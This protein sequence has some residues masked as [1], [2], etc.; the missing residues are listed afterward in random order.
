[1]GISIRA[2]ARHRGVAHNA[3][4]KAIKAGRIQLNKDKTIDVTQADLDWEQNTNPA[5]AGSAT[6]DSVK[7]PSLSTSPHRTSNP[8]P[9]TSGSAP[10]SNSYA[11]VRIAHEVAKTGLARQR[12]QEKKGQLINKDMV[13]AQIFRLGRQFRDSW[14]TWPSRVSAQMAAE[15][16]IDEHLLHL[17]LERYVREHLSEL[18]DATLNVE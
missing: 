10:N 18:G 6:T 11:Q 12:L 5:K 7:R 2:Y 4:C 9:A 13:K 3:V 1:M 15:L 17:T 16:Q 14:V 8:G